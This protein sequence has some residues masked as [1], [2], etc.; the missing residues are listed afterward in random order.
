MN[1]L[2]SVFELTTPQFIVAGP[3]INAFKVFPMLCIASSAT[4]GGSSYVIVSLIVTFPLTVTGVLCIPKF[5]M[6]LS[7]M[8][9]VFSPSPLAYL[10]FFDSY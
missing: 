3:S 5:A 9:Y 1:L 8:C 7:T 4:F 2:V 6:V 10:V